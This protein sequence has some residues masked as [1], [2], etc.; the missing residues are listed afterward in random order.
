MHR[1]TVAEMASLPWRKND[2]KEN[3]TRAKVRLRIYLVFRYSNTSVTS[4]LLF[5]L[6]ALR[7]NAFRRLLQSNILLELLFML[8]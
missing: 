6:F 4:K 3:A 1:E 7:K 8:G 2:R 5:F